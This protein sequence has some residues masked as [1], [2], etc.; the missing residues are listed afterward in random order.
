VALLQHFEFLKSGLRVYVLSQG[1]WCWALAWAQLGVG[2]VHCVPLSDAA[3]LSLGLLRSHP[4]LGV[5]LALARREDLEEPPELSGAAVLCAHLSAT[6]GDVDGLLRILQAARARANTPVLLSVNSGP[7]TSRIRALAGGGFAWNA[8]RHRSLGGGG[9]TTARLHVAWSIGPILDGVAP[10]RRRLPTRP[11]GRFLEPATKLYEWRRLSHCRDCWRPLREGATPFPWPWTTGRPWVEAPTCYSVGELQENG[12]KL[13]ERPLTDKERCQLLDLRDDWGCAV[14]ETVW[15]WDGGASPPLRLLAEFALECLP[16]LRAATTQELDETLE[17]SW[18]WGRNRPPWVE[19]EPSGDGDFFGW[20]WISDEVGRDVLAV[21]ADD[22]T[23]NLS[24]WAVGGP[25]E[26][27]DRARDGLC[28]FLFGFWIRRLCREGCLWLKSEEARSELARNREAVRDC[29][30][31]CANSTWWE[32]ADGSRLLFWRWPA[33]WRLEARDGAPGVHTGAPPPRQ[34]FPA[35]PIK[36][37]W[38][39]DK[40]VEKLTKLIHRRYLVPGEYRTAVPRFPVPKGADDIRVVW[41]LAK[42]GLNEHMFTPS[43][44]LPTMNT[45]LRRLPAGAYCGD[46]DIGEQFH[47]YILHESEQV[48][49]GVEVPLSVVERLQAEGIQ[50]TAPLRWGRLVF[51]WQSSPYLAL[52]M[53]TRAL[54]Y[55][56]GDPLDPGNAF[57]WSGVALNLPGAPGYDPGKPRVMKARLDGAPATEIVL[58][59]DDG[60]IMGATEELA[61]SRVR[62]A[63]ARLQHLGNQDAARKRRGVSQRPGAWAGGIVYTDQGVTRK[64]LSQEE[65]D[66]AK[67]FLDWV[68][69]GL[70]NPGG[71]ERKQFRSGKGFLVHVAQTYDFVQPYLKGFHLS[72]DGWRGQR[73]DEGWKYPAGGVGLDDGYEDTTLLGAE[74]RERMWNEPLA[75]EAPAWVKPVPRLADDVDVLLRFFAPSTPVQVIVR[76]IQGACY[77][78][79][80]A[81]DASGEGFGSALHPL[82]MEPLLRQ[83]FWCTES[84]E[85]SSNWRELRNLVDTVRHECALGRLAGRELWLATD[86]STAAAAYHHGASTSRALH[87]LVTELRLLA[88]RGNCVVNIFHISGTRMIEVGVDALSRGEM[89]LGEL[90]AV[91]LS[92]APLH[93]SPTQ[94]SFG[95]TNWLRSWLDPSMTVATPSDWFLDAQ[96]WGTHGCIQ[97]V[98]QTWVWDLAPAAAMHALEELGLA[99][100]KRH[101]LL[102]GVVLV[103]ALLQHEWHRRFIRVV[104]LYFQIAPGSIDEWPAQMHEPLTVGLFLPLLRIRPWS[105]K[106]APFMAALGV[107]LSKMYKAGDPDAGLVLCKFWS[108]ALGAP[109]MPK[110]MVSNLL[111]GS[112]WR[113]FLNLPPQRR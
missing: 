12:V 113:R 84:S 6:E 22:A 57:G 49:C 90:G 25:G 95:L 108:R 51:G 58:Y 18:D 21:K 109:F 88:L 15:A 75:S 36:E 72:E 67:I 16:L 92:A 38:V 91:P 13:I 105:W 64:L 40:D 14:L 33:A 3:T 62:Q 2:L 44:F 97:P 80:G 70:T 110:S 86:N 29:V 7:G 27:M 19:K 23:A 34:R 112:S 32:W 48:Y 99:R 89:H 63:T 104:D 41:D 66:R 4:P 50:I 102:R 55:A 45:Y 71:L 46:F 68:R 39:I 65:W 61:R 20:N 35:I 96:H 43:F 5:H 1:S 17:G 9:L 81:A 82:G 31:R 74:A 106:R 30:T 69:Q 54:E 83:G 85:Q 26:H 52:R 59:F 101:E 8:L 100:L 79:Y 37:Q 56:V 78:A 28:R 60:R 53:L 47:N 87:D 98:P 107:T 73:D 42:N 94:R 93:V 11:L 76:P 111:Q 103:P 10:G 24:L 77:V